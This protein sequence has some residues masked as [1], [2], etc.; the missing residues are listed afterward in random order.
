MATLV[1]TPQHGF[2]GVPSSVVVDLESTQRTGRVP[3]LDPRLDA[4]HPSL[5]TEL[6]QTGAII[7]TPAYMAPEQFNGNPAAEPS[8]QFSFCVAL[9]EGLYGERPFAGE[10]LEELSENVLRGRMRSAP[11]ST[12]V[13]GWLR[14]V[15]LRGLRVNPDERWASMDA[16]LGALQK[17]PGVV[18]RRWAM[19]AGALAGIAGIGIGARRQGARDNRPTCQ[20]AADRFARVWEPAPAGSRR[21]AIAAAFRATGAP[22]ATDA[23]NGTSRLLDRYVGAWSS[24][25]TDS[26]EATNVRGEQ[27]AEVLDLRTSCLHDRWNELRALSDVFAD[28]DGQVVANAVKAAAALTPLD[29]CADV[30]TLRAAVPPPSD[31]TV[32]QRV[33][34]LRSKLATAKALEAA[35]RF[36][37]AL[38]ASAR[39][40]ADARTTGYPPVLAETL[41]R[42]GA[43]QANLGR[44]SEAEV[45]LDEAVWIAEAARYDEIVAASSVDQ[46]YVVGSLEH[47]LPRARRWL[48]QAEAFLDRLEGHEILRAWMLNN[49]GTALEAHGDLEEA[50]P[51]YRNALQIKERVLGGLAPDV[52][53]SLGNLATTFA[54]LGRPEEAL[55]Y[56]N[57]SVNIVGQALGWEHPD[58]AIEL[59]VRAD[60]LNQV[61]RFS[62]ARNDALQALVVWEKELGPEHVFL[63]FI[64]GPL[65]EAN[66][67]LEQP[68]Q[69][70]VALDRALAIRSDGVSTLELRKLRFAL[71]RALWQTGQDP[72]RA[73]QLGV[74]AASVSTVSGDDAGGAREKARDRDLQVRAATWVASHK[75][76]AR[77]PG[78][79]GFRAGP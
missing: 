8:D 41:A 68:E 67:G 52:A 19:V 72:R 37:K 61:G 73:M 40:V 29:R 14:R 26:C 15:V 77:T 28:P 39:L 24:M 71:A 48:R 38:V 18:W 42:L 21:A 27:S 65:G 13:P 10:T 30:R 33:E 64:L 53:S 79:Q 75:G 59:S 1:T 11:L 44:G 25:Y 2:G 35:G 4:I 51:H 60:I 70:V 5:S 31:P 49:F 46:I 57:R 9:Y 56:S 34:T 76:A 16:L 58:T 36:A 17:D 50:L 43:I 3:L 55:E 22:Y 47:D 32:R 7:G 12:H 74:L 6:T 78:T 20:V 45:T 62:D 23:F 66:L 54:A 69:A 63:P